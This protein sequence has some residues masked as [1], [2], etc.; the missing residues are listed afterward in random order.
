MCVRVTMCICGVHVGEKDQVSPPAGSLCSGVPPP[1][2]APKTGILVL[3]ELRA[4]L[5]TSPIALGQ[6]HSILLLRAV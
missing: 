1:D 5:P 3:R 4:T 2:R 6:S